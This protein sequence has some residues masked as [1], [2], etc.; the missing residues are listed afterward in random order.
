MPPIAH[1][2]KGIGLSFELKPNVLK[3]ILN[4]LEEVRL[5]G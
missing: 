4:A 5:L 2:M 1:I 3:I